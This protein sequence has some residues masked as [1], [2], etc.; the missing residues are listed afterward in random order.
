MLEFFLRLHTLYMQTAV[1]D[2]FSDETWHSCPQVDLQI[3]ILQL[4][5]V[6]PYLV[7]QQRF[8]VKQGFEHLL[9]TVKLKQMEV[10]VAQKVVDSGFENDTVSI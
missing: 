3:F 10:I 7:M 9:R 8:L 6:K 5:P 1:H 2:Y 4:A